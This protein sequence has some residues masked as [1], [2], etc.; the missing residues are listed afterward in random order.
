MNECVVIARRKVSVIRRSD[1]RSM[2]TF[3][4]VKLRARR[5]NGRYRYH[6]HSVQKENGGT[7]IAESEVIKMTMDVIKKKFGEIDGLRHGRE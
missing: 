4:T 6:M 5:F 2:D 1:V 7:V 3:E